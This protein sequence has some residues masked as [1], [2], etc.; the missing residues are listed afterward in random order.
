M[1]KDRVLKNSLSRVLRERGDYALRVW[2][3]MFNF[4][5]QTFEFLGLEMH[6]CASTQKLLEIIPQTQERVSKKKHHEHQLAWY[7][8][9]S[10]PAL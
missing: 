8:K 4:R 6:S 2:R 7:Q 9:L 1:T 5:K 10:Q 3:R